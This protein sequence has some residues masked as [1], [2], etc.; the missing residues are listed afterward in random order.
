MKTLIIPSCSF[1]NTCQLTIDLLITNLNNMPEGI[2]PIPAFLLD[3]PYVEPIA[4]NDALA[5]HK[6]QGQVHT[7]MEIFNL[8]K[9]NTLFALQI[10]S[11]IVLGRTRDVA[12]EI[13]MMA[14]QQG[15]ERILVLAGGLALDDTER[16]ASR[17]VIIDT[18]NSIS[19]ATTTTT[20]TSTRVVGNFMTTHCIPL[21]RECEYTG[22][23]RHLLLNCHEANI[24]AIG[25]L[26]FVFEGDN[27]QDAH[28]LCKDVLTM[29]NIN[30][31]TTL[32]EPFSWRFV[33]R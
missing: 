31:V 17:T 30:N 22:M 33:N 1:G 3:S 2:A 13:I 19:P 32:Q 12:K 28:I 26:R 11:T 15:F 18:D 24:P 5:I 4:T 20:S 10:R 6:L 16:H 25:L 14:K 9:D 27:R 21:S 23:L 7:S 29:L 8:G